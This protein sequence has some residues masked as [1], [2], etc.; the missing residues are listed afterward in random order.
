MT[1]KSTQIDAD[2]DGLSDLEEYTQRTDPNTAD[3]DGD[4][5]SDAD[6]VRRWRTSPISVDT[7]A[8]ARGPQRNL[9]PA[10]ALFD[11]AERRLDA[12][13]SAPAANATSPT[14]DDTDGDARTDYEEI[15]PLGRSPVIA[16]LPRLKVELVDKID[17][18]LNVQYAENEGQSTSYG[19][20][21]THT[22][23]TS[24]TNEDAGKVGMKFAIGRK[25][26]EWTWGVDVSGEY[27]QRFAHTE[28]DSDATANSTL[29]ANLRNLTETVSTGSLSA[30]V[31]LSNVGAIAFTVADLAYTVRI[32]VP[33]PNNP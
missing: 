20:T 30:G 7:D 17:V 3:S 4:G 14:L 12:N 31:R 26:A 28:T 23:S 10:V 21:T 25:G 9:P 1:S 13:S 22:E 19:V 5:L 29:R 11:G 15:V 8:D 27:S 24:D 32:W 33:D 6:E 16:D 2:G 18:R